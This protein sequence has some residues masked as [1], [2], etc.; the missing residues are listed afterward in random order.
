M[1][2]ADITEA[3]LEARRRDDARQSV[4]AVLWVVG[5]VIVVSTILLALGASGIAGDL[6]N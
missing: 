5:I 3:V 1:E 6:A 4:R 2:R